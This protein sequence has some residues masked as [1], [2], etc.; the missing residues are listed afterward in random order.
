MV[1]LFLP[2]MWFGT[3]FFGI[4]NINIEIFIQISPHRNLDMRKNGEEEKVV[5]G[6]EVAT[7][8]YIQ[9]SLRQYLT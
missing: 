5:S 3:I 9:F 7:S 4:P 8:L 1:E 6:I 2:Y